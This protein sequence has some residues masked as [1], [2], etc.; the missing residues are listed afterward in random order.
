MLLIIGLEI[1]ITFGLFLF[2]N[3]SKTLYVLFSL[4]VIFSALFYIFYT[5]YREK[6]KIKPRKEVLGRYG[7]ILF[8]VF[9]FVFFTLLG[10]IIIRAV[11]YFFIY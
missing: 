11:S 3:A 10:I 8:S 1:V 9:T 6:I 5:R 2:V 4:L 7:K